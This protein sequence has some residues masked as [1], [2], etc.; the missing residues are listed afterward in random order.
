MFRFSNTEALAGHPEILNFKLLDSVAKSPIHLSQ[1]DQF[2]VNT[3]NTDGLI[4]LLI[5]LGL[6]LVETSILRIALANLRPNS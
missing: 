1:V 6:L 3:I 2:R 5:V 4:C